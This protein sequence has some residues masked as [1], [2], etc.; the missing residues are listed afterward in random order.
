M[1]VDLLDAVPG[2]GWVNCMQGGYMVEEMLMD[3]LAD[4]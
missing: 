1:G 3:K 4:G 2:D